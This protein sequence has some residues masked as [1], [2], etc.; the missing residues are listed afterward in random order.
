MSEVVLVGHRGLEDEL[1]ARLGGAVRVAIVGIG[2]ELQ[3]RDR[4]GILAVRELEGL[5]LC[6]VQVFNA[7]TVPEAI[8]GPV[9]RFRPDHIFLIDAADFGARPGTVAVIGPEGVVTRTLSTHALPLSVVM[10]YLEETTGS[11][12]TLIGVQPDLSSRREE[13]TAS[14]GAGLARIVSVLH[15]CLAWRDVSP[16]LRPRSS[17]AL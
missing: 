1:R 2:D 16:V 6:G 14:E 5:H 17:K 12:V 4:L 7:G 15:R 11:R 13:L 9:R 10:G 3:A 8:T